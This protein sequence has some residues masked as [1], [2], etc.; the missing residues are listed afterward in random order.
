MD[1]RCLGKNMKV[2]QEMREHL[3]DKLSKLDKYERKIVESHVVL[4]KEKY[5]YHA[6]ITLVGRNI[7]VF[8]DGTEKENLYAAIDKAID[9]VQK[10][11]KKF[12]D[13]IKDHHKEHGGRAVAPKERIARRMMSQEPSEG[14][15]SIVRVSSTSP[16]VMTVQEASMQLEVSEDPFIIFSNVSTKKP[17]VIFK[18]PDGNHGLVEP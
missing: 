14:G 3:A 12:R 13:K 6:Q 17:S 18:R 9:R 11:L 2:T 4:K 16:K 5:N 1:I 8:G 10:Q 15:P 7:Q